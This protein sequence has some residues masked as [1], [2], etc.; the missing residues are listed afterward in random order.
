MKILF[1]VFCSILLS[2]CTEEV[3]AP[4]ENVIDGFCGTSSFGACESSQDCIS[5][6]CSGQICRSTSEEGLATTCEWEDCYDETLYGLSCSC[7]EQS[8]QWA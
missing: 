3:A 7:V 8:C 4:E 5:D 2:G 1:L 6:G